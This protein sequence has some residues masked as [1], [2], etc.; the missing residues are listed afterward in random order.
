[1]TSVLF[2][3][4]E[5]DLDLRHCLIDRSR[6][7]PRPSTAL[8]IADASTRFGCAH[9]RFEVFF[10]SGGT[11][12]LF[13]HTHGLP[14]DSPPRQ[15]PVFLASRDYLCRTDPLAGCGGKRAKRAKRAIPLSTP[16]DI[17]LCTSGEPEYPQTSSDDADSEQSSATGTTSDASEADTSE[18]EADLGPDTIYVDLSPRATSTSRNATRVRLPDELHCLPE[19]V[20]AKLTPTWRGRLRPR[21]LSY[22]TIRS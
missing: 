19:V 17:D 20:K 12:V 2:D 16:D 10:S 5:S 21:V 18:Y 22:G 7:R 11:V 14:D 1:M 13:C 6:Y 15:W 4:P 3:T 8:V 9:D